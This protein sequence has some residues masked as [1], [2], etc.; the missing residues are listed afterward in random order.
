[1]I[2]Y[3]ILES[4]FYSNRSRVPC[5]ADRVAHQFIVMNFYVVK[6][7]V[8]KDGHYIAVCTLRKL[9][10]EI[11]V[12]YFL[13]IESKVLVLYND[14]LSRGLAEC[15]SYRKEALQHVGLWIERKEGDSDDHEFSLWAEQKPSD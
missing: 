2:V 12:I 11:P 14:F 6:D 3:L 7:C 13:Q 10:M 4:Q 15:W 9:K 8:L 5:H 1:M